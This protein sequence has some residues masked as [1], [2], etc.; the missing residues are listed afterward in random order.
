MSGPC[1]WR[2]P[3]K[4]GVLPR[5]TLT[6]SSTHY[7][8]RGFQAAGV[9][10]FNGNIISKFAGTIPAAVIVLLIE[11][12]AIAKSFGRVNNYTIDPVSEQL[13]GISFEDLLSRLY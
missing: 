3:S 6:L 2:I 12:I 1:I 5:D 13:S 11:H 9:P 8:P 4:L 7:R 10:R